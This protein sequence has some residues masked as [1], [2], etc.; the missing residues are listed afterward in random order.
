MQ[1]TFGP[2]P[3]NGKGGGGGDKNAA[4]P[5]DKFVRPTRKW[6]DAVDAFD[7]TIMDPDSFHLEIDFEDVSRP[8]IPPFPSTTE[9][10]RFGNA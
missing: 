1:I 10:H 5:L 9:F 6:W 3:S 7:P 2:R 8:G 4:F